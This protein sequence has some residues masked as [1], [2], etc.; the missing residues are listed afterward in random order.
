VTVNV[1]QT[2]DLAQRLAEAEAT[3]EALLSGQ[4]DAVV[5][6][7]SHTPV[8]L[9]QAQ[10]ALRQSQ[11]RLRDIIDGLGPSMFVGLLTPGG[12][13]LEANRPVL[14]AAGLEPEDVVGKPFEDT[15]WWSFSPESRARLRATIDRAARGEASRYD[16]QIRAAHGELIDV[17]FSLQPLR[18][19][20]GAVVFLVPSG[21]IITARKRTENAL[22][23]S[24]ENF[25]HL[26][27]NITDVFWIRSPDMRDVQYISPAYERI[28]G[29]RV[30]TLYS[31]PLQWSDHIL[32]EDRARVDAAFAT[33][34]G[35]VP[36]IDLEYRIVRPDGAIRWVRSRGFQVRDAAGTLIRLIGIITD[37]TAPRDLQ[38]Q[39]MVSD[40][41][42]SV[43]TLAAGV[44]HEINNPLAAVMANLEFMSESLATMGPQPSATWLLGELKEPLDEA[45]E[46]A[47]MVRL[48]VRDLKIFSRSPA[49]EPSGAVDV[50]AIMESSTRM[51]WNEIR[52]RAQLVKRYGVVP[53]VK[54][55][56]ARLGQVFLNLIVNAAQALPEGRAEHNEICVSTRLEGKRVIV[57]V[58]DT[59]SGIRP[60]II[61]RIF[62]A[63][64]TTKPIGVGTG[65]GLAICHRIVTDMGGE[66]TVESE[67][68]KGTTFRVALPV[69]DEPA[70][71]AAV[72]IAPSPAMG[73]RGRIL[74]VDD[75][76]LVLQGVKRMLLKEHDVVA[77]S[78]AAEALALCSGGEKFDV[79]LCD[80]MMPDMTGMD[81]HAELSRVAP[82]LVHRIIFMTGGAFTARAQQFL[83]ET[84]IEHIEKP[85][86]PAN[87]RAI[88]QRHLR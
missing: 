36:S 57:E 46:A 73:R 61:G 44:A 82:D 15:Y 18:D 68:G 21:T 51:A 9:A 86:H 19:E 27:D 13:L 28:W 37:M 38:A 41:M 39:L 50:K 31:Q 84:L 55:N 24:N 75:E 22:R 56:E 47:Q 34:R 87:L 4:I 78:A 76:Q 60:E 80:L 70:S 72:L 66:L 40:R 32:P 1:L 29:R 64:F 79:I 8:L 2:P 88:I 69:A 26:A 58:S 33:L 81:F 77:V 42:A 71:K 83:S 7:K 43:G 63:F 52:H 20:T 59:G 45:R 12:I 23:E 30:D 5:D 62:D 10:E 74:V 49:D 53:G 85:F 6:S 14:E 35:D 25:H 11:K 54:A 65:L 67:V 16:V 17:D 48:I 3:I